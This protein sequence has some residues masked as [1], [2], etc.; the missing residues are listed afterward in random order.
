MSNVVARGA[1]VDLVQAEEFYLHGR[2]ALDN[3]FN[4]FKTDLFMSSLTE[5]S[6]RPFSC[7]CWYQH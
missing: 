7:L 4:V 6:G 3:A 2:I 5:S 1:F